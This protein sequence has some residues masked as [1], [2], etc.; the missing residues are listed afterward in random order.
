M[1]YYDYQQVPLQ[2]ADEAFADF[3]QNRHNKGI[4]DLLS[5]LIH[6]CDRWCQEHNA[7]CAEDNRVAV[8]QRLQAYIHERYADELSQLMRQNII[9]Y[10][11]RQEI[12]ERVE[13]WKN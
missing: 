13:K 1:L 9:K 3:L 4:L 12:I 2:V 7:L 10:R 6:H 5:D 8:V 11:E